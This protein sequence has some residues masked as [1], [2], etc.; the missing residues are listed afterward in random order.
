MCVNVHV[1][2]K[3]IFHPLSFIKIYMDRRSVHSKSLKDGGSIVKKK[4]KKPYSTTV[5]KSTASHVSLTY[6]RLLNCTSHYSLPFPQHCSSNLTAGT[7]SRTSY[8]FPKRQVYLF[9]HP[10]RWGPAPAPHTR[11]PYWPQAEPTGLGQSG[12]APIAPVPGERAAPQLRGPRRPPTPRV[13]YPP[14][15]P[16]TSRCRLGKERGLRTPGR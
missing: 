16:R 1:R 8:S 9:P 2:S 12:T 14:P 15:R 7:I 3:G 10:A 4:K 11:R 13:S 5:W 6:T